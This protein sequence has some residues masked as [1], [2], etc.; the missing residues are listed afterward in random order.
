MTDWRNEALAPL[1]RFRK[2]MSSIRERYN[3]PSQSNNEGALADAMDAVSITNEKAGLSYNPVTGS[4]GKQQ[5]SR[6]GFRSK[7]NENYWLNQA[8]VFGNKYGLKFNSIDDVISFQNKLGV[9]ADGKIGANTINAYIKSISGRNAN[10][11]SKENNTI[12]APYRYNPEPFETRF[13]SLPFMQTPSL[14]DDAASNP[15]PKSRTAVKNIDSKENSTGSPISY[16]AKKIDK[17]ISSYAKNR[18]WTNAGA[19]SDVYD[20]IT[21]YGVFGN[22]PYRMQQ[23]GTVD[24]QVKFIQ[25]IAE[26]LGV[27]NEQELRTAIKKIGKEGIMQLKKAFDSGIPANKIKESMNQNVQYAKNGASLCPQGTTLVFKKGGC[28]CEKKQEGGNVPK[29]RFQ[30]KGEIQ[31]KGRVNPNDTVHIKGQVYDITGKNGKTRYRKMT[32]ERFRKLP[33][34]DQVRIEEKDFAAGRSNVPIGRNGMSVNKDGYNQYRTG[35]GLPSFISKFVTGDAEKMKCGGKTKKKL[36][37]K[38]R[39]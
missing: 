2:D 12:T 30:S 6:P 34:E 22:N 8:N 37:P 15:V 16:I 9:N 11:I 31:K 33:L 18:N 10:T 29:K 23:G 3:P 39:K 36:V 32:N 13:P 27:T 21:G 38:K 5:Y 26:I 35:L 4:W 1:E 7:Q 20:Q 19:M 28:I 25:Y 24:N 17:K 14:G